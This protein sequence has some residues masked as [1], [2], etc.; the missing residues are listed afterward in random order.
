MT[1]SA[2]SAKQGGDFAALDSA[3][4]LDRIVAF[5]RAKADYV[6]TLA[7][8]KQFYGPAATCKLVNRQLYQLEKQKRVAKV[9]EE[10]GANPR[11]GAI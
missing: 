1:T 5:L 2:V 11:W 7:V 8:A 10:N 3:A 6:K 9:A 4:Q